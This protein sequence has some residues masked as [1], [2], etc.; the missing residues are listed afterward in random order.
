MQ[1]VNVSNEFGR[2]RHGECA[3]DR[4]VEGWVREKIEL[5][6]EELVCLG[7]WESNRHP[8]SIR[9][10][11]GGREVVRRRERVESRDRFEGGLDESFDLENRQL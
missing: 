1:H 6:S 5:R 4:S 11:H 9:R 7:N 2:E 8:V 10:G 3:R